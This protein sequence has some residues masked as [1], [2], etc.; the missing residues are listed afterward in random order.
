MGVLFL[1]IEGYNVINIRSSVI[2]RRGGVL[3]N[4]FVRGF[5]RGAALLSIFVLLSVWS[6]FLG[7]ADN[8]RVFLY[9]GFIAFFLG[10]GSVLYQ[11]PHWSFIKRIIIHYLATLPTVF[12]VLLI[13]HYDTIHLTIDIV[14]AFFIF[15][16]LQLLAPSITYS[17][18]VIFK[19]YGGKYV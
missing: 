17:L 10:F 5:F 6:L 4:L 9:Y 8:V 2:L 18:S 14:G 3:I 19:R 11:V 13:I 7:P 15:N 16:I 12:P 1:D